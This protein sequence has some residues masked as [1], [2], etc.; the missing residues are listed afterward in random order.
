[1]T[2]TNIQDPATLSANLWPNIIDGAEVDG[3]GAETPRESPAHDVR[4]AVYH[5][6]GEADVIGAVGCC[7][8]GVRPRRVDQDQRSREGRPA[9]PG[10]R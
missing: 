3:G 6:A 5:S 8:P 10:W 9:P 2:I 7:R 1:M 4:V